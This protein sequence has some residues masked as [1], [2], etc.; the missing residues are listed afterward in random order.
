MALINN[1]LAAL[2][3]V[4]IDNCLFHYR[5]QRFSAYAWLNLA[6]LL[7]LLAMV[8]FAVARLAHFWEMRQIHA[9]FTAAMPAGMVDFDPLP[10]D[11][12]L[13]RFKSFPRFTEAASYGGQLL[14]I[15]QLYLLLLL[16]LARNLLWWNKRRWDHPDSP[17]IRLLP[18]SRD[19][20]QF[21]L[22]DLRFFVMSLCILF[23]TLLLLL[24]T[25]IM[26]NPVFLFFPN[27]KWKSA[28]NLPSVLLFEAVAW[29]VIFAL[30]R[31]MQFQKRYRWNIF[32]NPMFGSWLVTAFLWIVFLGVL[33]YI[34][35]NISAA[36]YAKYSLLI[37]FSFASVT[38]AILLISCWILKRRLL[39]QPPLE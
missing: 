39:A 34:E 37:A 25:L 26:E 20:V 9:A 17:H 7:V 14:G 29:V 27:S 19:Q 6:T 31:T 33:K 24:P 4:T 36:K 10:N 11:Y 22:V 8:L 32:R 5:L 3:H 13:R 18:V 28:L 2:R 30:Y 12:D 35:P 21:A 38:C 16:E 1:R 23:A 15:A